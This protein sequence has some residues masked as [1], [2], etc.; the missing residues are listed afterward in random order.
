MRRHLLI[1]LLTLLA[2][3]PTLDAAHARQ[4]K[5]LKVYISAD[6][7]G[8]SGVSTW[9]VQSQSNGREFEKFARLMTQEVNAAIAGA[10]DAG[11]SDVLVSDF[12]GTRRTSTSSYSTSG[13]GW[14]APGRGHSV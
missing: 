10:F 6:M 14:S 3:V 7:E 11:A 4:S 12:T 5:K 13:R 9:K 2:L 8:V 1:T